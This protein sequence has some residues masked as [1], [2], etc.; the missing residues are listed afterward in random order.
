MSEWITKFRRRGQSVQKF[1]SSETI[2][3]FALA[4]TANTPVKI[5]NKRDERTKGISHVYVEVGRVVPTGR[6][7]K[8]VRP[9]GDPGATG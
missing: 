6:P 9:R 4:N 2:N 7:Q 5:I 3:C 8:W 1:H